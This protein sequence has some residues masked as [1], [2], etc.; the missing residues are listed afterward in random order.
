MRAGLFD[1]GIQDTAYP[2]L[3]FLSQAETE[4]VLLEH[5]ATA[6]VDSTVRTLAGMGFAG[7]S[8]PQTFVLADLEA[9]GDLQRGTIHVYVRD[10]GMLFLFPLGSPATWRLIGMQPRDGSGGPR[11]AARPHDLSLEDLRALADSFTGGA[12]RLRD[13]VWLTAFQLQHR[14]ASRYRAGRVFLAGDA[15]HVH[16][17][18]GAQGMNTGIQDARPG[19]GA[20][21]PHRLA[22]RRALPRQPRRPGGPA[23]TRGRAEGGRP[24]PRRPPSAQRTAPLAARVAARARLPPAALRAGGRLGRRG[25][26]GRG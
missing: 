15:A 20:G 26:G 25:R 2:F 4:R 3:L 21:V 14:Q 7:G 1:I 19:Q 22:A 16:S 6:G 11:G 5:L 9:D 8:Y 17:P 23:S 18:V 12:V 13:P 10:A 24:A